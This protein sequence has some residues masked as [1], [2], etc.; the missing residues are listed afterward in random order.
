MVQLPEQI[1]IVSRDGNRASFEISPLL[2]GYGPTIANPL[3]RV[4]LSSLE[5]AAVT[6]IKIKGIDH[7]FSALSGVLEDVIELILNI[8]KIRFRLYGD[9]PVKVT[10]AEKGEKNIIAG[11]IKLTSDIEIINDDQHIATI[12]DKKTT[13][14]IEMEV[15]KG[16][17]YV[18]VE[19]RQ[20]EKLAI[21]V[22]AIDAIFSPVKIVNFTVE[23]VRVGQRIDFNKILMDIETDGSI[24]PDKA[25]RNA[26]E[27][28]VNHFKIIEDS[29]EDKEPEKK[30]KKSDSKEEKK[31]K[32]IARKKVK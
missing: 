14:E 22:I 18:P 21:G 5:G 23:N 12:T 30:K 32:K 2:P 16:I 9:G 8:K 25:I 7:E 27:I 4:L 26:A 11:N 17:G 20:K 3:R 24:S 28:L 10:L 6:S 29:I 13:L 1:K 31:E 15:E 19:Q